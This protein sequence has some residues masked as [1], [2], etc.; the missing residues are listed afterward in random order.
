MKHGG[1]GV[2]CVGVEVRV[3]REE[4]SEESTVS[5]A[6]DQGAATIEQLREIVSAAVFECFAEGEVFEPAIRFGDEVEVGLGAA[7][8]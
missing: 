7:H 8:R 2:D 6:E 3:L 5:V 4:L 1:A